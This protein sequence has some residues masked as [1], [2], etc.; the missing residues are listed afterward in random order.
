MRESSCW[1]SWGS[2]GSTKGHAAHLCPFVEKSR[3]GYRKRRGCRGLFGHLNRGQQPLGH[4][5][6]PPSFLPPPSS[7][8]CSFRPFP[9]PPFFIFSTSLL[10][11]VCS[12][13]P[14]LFYLLPAPRF[15]PSLLFPFSCTLQPPDLDGKWE[16]SKVLSPSESQ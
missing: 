2:W 7:F 12:L 3:E 10:S 11:L 14:L 5:L 9:P 6:S 13:P 8:F 16:T 15:P 4:G 1:G